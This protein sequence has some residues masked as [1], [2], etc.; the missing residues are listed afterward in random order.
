[1]E[2][3][4]EIVGFA[5]R[6]FVPCQGHNGGLALLW[7]REINLEIKN[8]G[9]HHIDAIIIEETSNFKWRFTGF[10]GHPQTHMRQ[11][12]WDLL[13]FL[14][15]QSQLPW[16]CFGDFNEVLSM[17]KKSSGA[18]R[19]Q[20]QMDRAGD[21]RVYLR[22]DRAFATSDWFDK[23]GEVKVNHLVYSTSDHC[24]LYVAD[25]KAPKQPNTRCFHFEA[26]W[27]KSDE[28]RN[29]IEAVWSSAGNVNT[30]KGMAAALKACAMDLKAWSSATFKQIPKKIQEKRKRL[31]NLVQ[32]DR[33]GQLGEEI[34]QARKDINDLID[35]EEIYWCQWS[36][37]HWLREGDRNTKFFHA[38]DSERRKQNTI[39]GI[40]DIF[41]SWCGDQDS[42]A[43]VAIKE[44]NFV[45]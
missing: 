33:D 39:L 25:P 1:M 13:E 2:R 31:S 37:A 8:F 19:S 22:L 16:F 38:Q 17:D 44:V 20:S 26:M 45:P 11:Q 27:A 29:I 5:N 32:L 4:K 9:N 24:A 41:D 3:I 35:S 14:K 12:S 43:R 36:K 30:A 28:C 7:T 40:W 21:S 18:V 23:F 10:Y 42:I 15:N 34:N 6:L